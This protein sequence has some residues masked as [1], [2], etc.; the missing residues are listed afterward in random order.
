MEDKPYPN[1]LQGLL[2]TTSLVI[3][4]VASYAL[5]SI[6]IRLHI[7]VPGY[8]VPLAY[9][10]SALL[11]IPIIFYALKKSKIN[12]LENIRFPNLI[13]C[14]MLVLLA[15]S[16]QVLTIP[17][18]NPIKFIHSF[19]SGEIE[20]L[21]FKA[22]KPDTNFIITF[23][24]RVILA[25]VLEEVFFRGILLYQFLKRFS[26]QKAILLSTLLFAFGHLRITDVVALFADGLIFG[27][28]YYKTNSIVASILLHSFGNLI[29]QVTKTYVSPIND[30][31]LGSFAFIMSISILI[32]YLFVKYIDHFQNKHAASITIDN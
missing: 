22:F 23:I 29:N 14:S 32:I 1:F 2:L 24:H 20:L 4:L 17:L 30:S 15:V 28:V 9:A 5:E 27:Y 6:P 10:F 11:F 25:P 13:I 16:L 3:I 31:S 7:N 21:G 18:I 26:P 19:F 12:I 8:Y